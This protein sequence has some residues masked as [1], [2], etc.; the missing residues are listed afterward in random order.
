M[1]RENRKRRPLGRRFHMSW[2]DSRIRVWQVLSADI[3][4][5][6]WPAAANPASGGFGVIPK[7]GLPT[8]AFLARQRDRGAH[9][10]GY[11]FHQTL[12]HAFIRVDPGA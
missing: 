4:L 8:L 7:Q 12:H 6:S 9:T 1:A 2:S 3:A 10:T 5:T 11:K